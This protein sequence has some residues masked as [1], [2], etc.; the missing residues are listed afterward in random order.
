MEVALQD[1]LET[2]RDVAGTTGGAIALRKADATGAIAGEEMAGPWAVVGLPTALARH[3]TLWASA[4]GASRTVVAVEE[5]PSLAALALALQAA[6]LG[7]V[8]GAPIFDGRGLLVGGAVLVNLGPPPLDERILRSLERLR[9]QVGLLF[10]WQRDRVYLDQL[11]C[12]N[13]RAE[14]LARQSESL[15]QKALGPRDRPL[16]PSLLRAVRQRAQGMLV[17]LAGLSAFGTDLGI[18]LA[19]GQTLKGTIARCGQA[20]E[21]HLGIDRLWIWLLDHEAKALEFQGPS[22]PPPPAIAGADFQRP[23]HLTVTA[24]TA[25]GATASDGTP[26]TSDGPPQTD[27]TAPEPTHWLVDEGPPGTYTLPPDPPPSETAEPSPGP[28]P[29]RACTANLPPDGVEPSSLWLPPELLSWCQGEGFAS[30]GRYPMVVNDRPIGTAIVLSHHPL[31][32]TSSHM[33]EWAANSIAVVFDRFQ[34]REELLRRREKLMLQLSG[35]IHNSLDLDTILQTAVTE[36]RSLFRI[37]DCYFLWYLPVGEEPNATTSHYASR[38]GLP[39]LSLDRLPNYTTSLARLILDLAPIA[40]HNSATGEESDVHGVT[41]G[42]GGVPC[43]YG[44]G[45]AASAFPEKTSRS[46]LAAMPGAALMPILRTAGIA[47]QLV[48]PLKT[49]SGQYGAIACSN[50]QRPRQWKETEIELLQAAVDRLAIAI[51]QAELYAQARATAL[52]A[53]SQAKRLSETLDNLKKAEA[54]LVQNEKMSSLGQ[55]VAG[56]AHEINNPVSFIYGNLD[57]LRGYAQ[58]TL[59]LI[60]LYQECYPEPHPKIA[61]LCRSIDLDF[62]IED[63][64]KLI[65]SMEMGT[66]RIRQIVMSL[67]NFSRLDEA[68]I[69]QVD[70]HEGIDSTLLILQSRLK[71]SGHFLGVEVTKCYGD[72][73]PVECYAGQLNQVFMNI[74]GNAIDALEVL[75]RPGH[76]TITTTQLEA[77]APEDDE[78]LLSNPLDG[79]PTACIRIRD[80]G[81]GITEEVRS[82]LFDPFFTTK[83]VGKGTGLGLSICYQIVVD[84][85][86]GALECHSVPEGGTEFLIRIPMAL[87]NHLKPRA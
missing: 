17:E 54:Q 29:L 50:R 6:R 14:R 62:L 25:P 4:L 1:L 85:H 31:G 60:G 13:H 57:H 28:L 9:G 46:P 61:T 76:I 49:R 68:A 51:D 69:K 18:A 77:I 21:A 12:Q 47:S 70:I 73:L 84:K 39:D 16:Y 53:Q 40:I 83:P 65:H 5:E 19:Q 78:R 2:F 59:Q 87:P 22:A 80:D 45:E 63:M 55:M 41:Y 79:V 43:G 20:M 64:P 71:P 11:R 74:I 33:L 58:D 23:I 10:D 15:L 7:F 24:A 52:A 32:D 86:G 82:H 36:I 35:Q 3:L 72:L 81:V 37:D 26:P 67:R 34:A 44:A 38:E 42:G 75:D 30:L 8:W 66:E 48:V 56:V 27:A